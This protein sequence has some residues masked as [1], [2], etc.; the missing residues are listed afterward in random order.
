VNAS[1]LKQ[2]TFDF[3]QRVIRLVRALPKNVEGRA[4]G[5]QLVRCGTAVGAN[6]RATCKARSRAEFIAK[7]GVVEEEADESAYWLETIMAGQILKSALVQ[8]LLEE[9]GALERIFGQSRVTAIR[10]KPRK[11]DDR[12]QIGNRK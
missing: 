9:A 4:I 12:S 3:G 6:Y 1:E 5:A 11:V 2:R 10:A 7:M 8:S